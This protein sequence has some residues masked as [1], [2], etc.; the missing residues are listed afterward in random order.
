MHVDVRGGCV[1]IVVEVSL[2]VSDDRGI[3]VS[4]MCK[5]CGGVGGCVKSHRN[6]PSVSSDGARPFNVTGVKLP[7][8]PSAK[9]L[10]PENPIEA[11]SL[12]DQVPQ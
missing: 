5:G 1:L 6:G 4:L 7:Q 10:K 12:T 8:D 3:E 11:R 2:I 9:S